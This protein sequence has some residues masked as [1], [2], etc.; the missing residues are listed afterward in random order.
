MSTGHP[1]KRTTMW[2]ALWE[3]RPTV[4]KNTFFT[5]SVKVLHFEIGLGWD[6][7]FGGVPAQS[8]R[9]E[10]STWTFF[11]RLDIFSDAT[12]LKNTL[13][14]LL[15]RHLTPIIDSERGCFF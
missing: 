9:R 3:K 13:V 4:A 14:L 8:S 5:H 11:D 12:D 10:A 2:A 1:E 15:L 6:H 7:F